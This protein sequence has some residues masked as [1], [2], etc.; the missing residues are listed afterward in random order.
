MGSHFLAMGF[1]IWVCLFSFSLISSV[2]SQ[3]EGR[4]VET[5]SGSVWIDVNSA[6]GRTDSDFICATLDWWPPE[7]CDYGTCSWGHASLLN[8]VI[9]ICYT[10]THIHTHVCMY[11]Y[12]TWYAHLLCKLY[13]CLWKCKIGCGCGLEIGMAI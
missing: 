1:C 3:N 9:P 4:R 11:V 13:L 10:H 8:L 6:I 7:K 2:N 5:V 12:A